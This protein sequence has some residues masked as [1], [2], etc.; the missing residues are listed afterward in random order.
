MCPDLCPLK[1]SAGGP[2]ILSQK[3]HSV[4]FGA[5]F[6]RHF[7][8]IFTCNLIQILQLCTLV[9][10]EL[11]NLVCRKA[12]KVLNTS[13]LIA[14]SRVLIRHFHFLWFP[15]PGIRNKEDVNRF[16]LLAQF[17]LCG[18]TLFICIVFGYGCC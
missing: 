13:T 7:E 17:I 18:Y 15:C 8:H 4:G 3:F 1:C 12:N 5:L 6:T 9:L 2:L 14:H 11:Q 16:R 10:F